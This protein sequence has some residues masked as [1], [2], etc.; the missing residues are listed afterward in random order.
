[1]GNVCD[2]THQAALRGVVCVGRSADD[3]IEQRPWLQPD[4]IDHHIDKGPE[5]QKE[6]LWLVKRQY[7]QHRNE[8]KRDAYKGHPARVGDIAIDERALACAA[9]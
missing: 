7:R 9:H 5:R 6:R 4:G 3:D 2:I 8:N 1:M